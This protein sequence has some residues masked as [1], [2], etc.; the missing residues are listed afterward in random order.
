MA[1]EIKGGAGD[2][3]VSL[4]DLDQEDPGQTTDNTGDE[5]TE[6]T[7]E[8]EETSTEES[9]KDGEEKEEEEKEETE[10]TEEE[11][12]ADPSEFWTAVDQLHGFE[13]FKVEYPDGI[14]PL[15]PEGAH[16][17]EK[18][19]MEHAIN[20]FDAHLKQKDPRGYE[21]LLHRQNGGDDESFFA[22]QSVVLPDA[23]AF[24][25]SVDLQKD[26]LTR[27]LINKGNSPEDAKFI[28]EKAIADQKLFERATNAYKTI[29][30][31][32]ADALARAEK[33]AA[34]RVANEQKALQTMD[35]VI[36][37]VIMNSKTDKI[38]IPDAKRAEFAQFVKDHMYYDG[39]KFFIMKP[40]DQESAA[41]QIQGEYFSFV[42]GNL[43]D[44]VERS[45]KT[46]NTKKLMLGV[47]QSKKSAKSSTDTNNN[48]GFIPLGSL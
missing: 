31:A 19:L 6:E 39:E 22:R 41:Q 12:S 46:Q 14:N 47:Q 28:V 16:I 37:D 27:D 43:K 32:E 20:N 21:Y 45:A 3:I 35:S 11:E 2:E 40:I 29:E 17:R 8:T 5:S 48:G 36:T 18:A 26:I 44:L 4:A 13:D 15:S 33:A 30:K 24:K 23:E 1:D 7:T 34:D 10:E 25:N 9:T 42:K 38:V